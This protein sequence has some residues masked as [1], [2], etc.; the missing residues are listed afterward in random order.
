M[1]T[2]TKEDAKVKVWEMTRKEFKSTPIQKTPVGYRGYFGLIKAQLISAPDGH[3]YKLVPISKTTP[4]WTEY[5]RK[6]NGWKYAVLNG[7]GEDTGIR[8]HKVNELYDIIHR[9]AIEQ[10]LKEGKPIPPDVLKE[11]PE[12]MKEK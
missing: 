7:K 9:R 1:K 6:K 4:F 8:L 10:A 12:L 2:E 3:V 5:G 11:Y